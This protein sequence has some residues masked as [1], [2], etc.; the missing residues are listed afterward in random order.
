MSMFQSHTQKINDLF[1]Y[2]EELG[3]VINH[4]NWPWAFLTSI[5]QQTSNTKRNKPLSQRQIE[6]LE[7]VYSK[8]SR[9]ATELNSR[10]DIE[11]NKKFEEDLQARRRT[12]W[13]MESLNA[14]ELTSYL[15]FTKESAI[16]RSNLLSSGYWSKARSK[17]DATG[18]ITE[19]DY[20]RVVVE[21]KYS[22]RLIC[23]LEADPTYTVGQLINLRSGL[24]KKILYRD[25][26]V[27]Y[28]QVLCNSW[29][30]F[31]EN[32]ETIYCNS[33][34][35][36]SPHKLHTNRKR[37]PLD[38]LVGMIVQHDP[39]PSLS[40]AKGCRTYKIMTIGELAN[41]IPFLTVEERWIKKSPKNL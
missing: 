7:M 13:V 39:V 3:T 38:P 35:S 14:N 9:N 4:H 5:R 6:V 21:N 34:N 31:V 30:T 12:Q 24:I 11:W 8:W 23:A 19:H 2:H 18:Q 40:N 33:L 17:W 22:N 15:S 29:R 32:K 16:S 20:N 36:Y 28:Y 37:N 26:T 1:S 27:Q 25:A 10:R 41:L